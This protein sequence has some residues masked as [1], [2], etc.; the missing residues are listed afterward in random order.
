LGIIKYSIKKT[1]L[2]INILN[3]Q[4]EFNVSQTNIGKGFLNVMKNTGLQGRWQQLGD[5]PKI[6]CDNQQRGL[7]YCAKTNQKETFENYILY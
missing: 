2:T 6:I 5:S 1:A 4:K 3:A 7:I